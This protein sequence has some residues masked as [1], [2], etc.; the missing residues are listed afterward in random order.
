[1]SKRWT[2]NQLVNPLGAVVAGSVI[3]EATESI[4]PTA[5]PTAPV[6]PGI[7]AQW[8]RAIS[9][10]AGFQACYVRAAQMA[11]LTTGGPAALTP[12][13]L[14]NFIMSL[15][16]QCHNFMPMDMSDCLCNKNCPPPA[17]V[18]TRI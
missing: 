12:E 8:A 14:Q 15:C 2:V 3:R 9:S 13:K 16:T 11:G 17:Q 18:R 4:L 7:P 10:D 5:T 6:F 1:M